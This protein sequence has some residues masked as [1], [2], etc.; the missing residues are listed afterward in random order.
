MGKTG[1]ALFSR[2][3]RESRMA[4]PQKFVELLNSVEGNEIEFSYAY[5]NDLIFTFTSDS[6]SIVDTV[7]GRD[8]LDFDVTYFR[9]WD[10][11]RDFGL[12]CAIYLNKHGKKF[13]DS[14]IYANGSWSKLTQ[15]ARLWENGLPIPNTIMAPKE[16]WPKIAEDFKYPV[17]LKSKSGTRGEA[18][19]LIKSPDELY[20]IVAAEEEYKFF[21]QNFIPNDGDYRVM[22]M[23]DEIQ[24]LIKRTAS[25][26]HLNNISK[27]GGAELLDVSE[28]TPQQQADCLKAAKVFGR[29]IAGVDMVIDSDTGDHSFFEVNRAPQID[30][31]SFEHEKAAKLQEFFS[32]E[33]S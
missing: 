29:D 24:L 33:I 32:Q 20:E 13:Y 5:F 16:Y 8:L 17:I 31:S 3:S 18:N 30:N 1:L 4:D 22:T 7:S 27:G 12:T 14:E 26:G 2:S 21:V 19:H 11:A 6:A 10:H 28:L 9:R 23:G 25:D 15:Y